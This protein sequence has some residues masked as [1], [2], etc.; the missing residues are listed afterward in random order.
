MVRTK[1]YWIS[2]KPF[3]SHCWWGQQT[4]PWSVSSSQPCTCGTFLPFLLPWS[5]VS[6]FF[7]RERRKTDAKDKD[8]DKDKDKK[9]KEDKKVK[10]DSQ[11]DQDTKERPTS[12]KPERLRVR[13]SLSHREFSWLIHSSSGPPVTRGMLSS[14]KKTQ[15]RVLL[16]NPLWRSR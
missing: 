12:D 16:Q 3:H 6:F 10:D 8:K 4:Y 1:I 13:F 9:D 14:W 7:Q 15:M 11:K 5:H 2:T